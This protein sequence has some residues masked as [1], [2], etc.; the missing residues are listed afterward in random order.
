MKKVSRLL[1]TALFIICFFILTPT[2]L[3]TTAYDGSQYAVTNNMSV[4]AT[5]EPRPQDLTFSMSSSQ[6]SSDTASEGQEIQFNIHYRSLLERTWPL[7]LKTYWDKGVL[8]DSEFNYVDVFEYVLNSATNTKGNEKPIIN[9]QER[10]IT[11][12]IPHIS[13]TTTDYVVSFNLRVRPDLPTINKIRVK[14]AANAIFASAGIPEQNLTIFVKKGLFPI[15]ITSGLSIL[16]I[17]DTSIS[18]LLRSSEN[19]NYQLIYGETLQSLNN[20]FSSLVFENAHQ[21]SLN[22]LTSEKQYFFR[23]ILKNPDGKQLISETFT[24][25]TAAPLSS[26][27]FIERKN[28]FLS[29]NDIPLVNGNENDNTLVLTKT[30]KLSVGIKLDHPESIAQIVARFN[31][32][33][34]LGIDTFAAEPP[35]TETRLIETLPGYFSGQL[36]SP[37]T[38]GQY[39]VILDIKDTGGGMI[40]KIIPQNIYISHPLTVIDNKKKTPIEK[41]KIIIYIQKNSTSEF[42][43]FEQTYSIYHFT[44]QKGILDINL[45]PNTY[46]FDVSAL[47]YRP[48]KT[49]VELAISSNTYP[50]IEMTPTNSIIDRILYYLS[51]I[52]FIFSSILYNFQNSLGSNQNLD[53]IFIILQFAVIFSALFSLSLRLQVGS[54]GLFIFIYQY[55][56]YHI[57]KWLKLSNS[58]RFVVYEQNMHHH[59]ISGVNIYILDKNY[60]LLK[61]L[62]SDIVGCAEIPSRFLNISL[63]PLKIHTYRKGYVSY[64]ISIDTSSLTPDIIDLVMTKEINDLESVSDFINWAIH[65]SIILIFDLIVVGSSLFT[66]F[67]FKYQGWQKSIPFIITNGVILLFWAMYIVKIWALEHDSQ[68]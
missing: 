32:S 3:P 68:N 25:T 1:C 14:V 63:T 43:P 7:Q 48:V 15:Q 12:S 41:A 49:K 24:F 20:S 51:S 17:T 11:W 36:Q 44:N 56:I 45:P 58:K 40:S 18:M 60:K 42:I 27:V 33:K 67:L 64:P 66:F 38:L 28:I 23:Y 5:V 6:S 46:L 57:K 13:T 39:N 8:I 50:Q 62:K 10:S 16:E 34:I 19:T 9:L 29:S 53:A 47:G 4:T 54:L 65:V 59:T 37:D 30:S 2:Q 35:S 31:N 26:N 61:K 22:N 21:I 52:E 55:F